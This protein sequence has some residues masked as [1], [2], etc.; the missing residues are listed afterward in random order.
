MTDELEDEIPESVKRLPNF[1][2]GLSFSGRNRTFVKK[3]AEYL[4][5]KLGDD[6]VFYDAWYSSKLK[7]SGADKKLA[8]IY[9]DK[10]KLIVP[11]FSEH[12]E[13]S[14]WLGRVEWPTIKK[15]IEARRDMVVPVLLDGVRASGWKEFGLP[16]RRERKTAAKVAEEILDLYHDRVSGAWDVSIQDLSHGLILAADISNFSALPSKHFRD[17]IAKL[18]SIPE[19]IGLF[20]DASISSLLDGLVAARGGIRHAQLLNLCET[21]INRL[22]V[23]TRKIVQDGV[24]LRI[25]VHYGSYY[26]INKPAINQPKLIVGAAPNECSR[27]VRVA[28]PG[29]VVVSEEFVKN[30]KADEDSELLRHLEPPHTREPIG[31]Y[32]KPGQLSQFRFYKLN[33]NDSPQDTLQQIHAAEEALHKYLVDIEEELVDL[34]TDSDPSLDSKSIGARLTIFAV[35]RLGLQ[36]VPTQI[37]YQKHGNSSV[38]AESV[39]GHRLH[40]NGT[41]YSIEDKKKPQGPLGRAYYSFEPQAVNKLPSYANSPEKYVGKLTRSPWYI[42]RQMV[43]DFGHKA[44]AF[45]AVPFG[46]QTKLP[47]GL[48]CIDTQNPLNSF[49]ASQLEECGE[50]IRRIYGLL[51]ASLLRLRS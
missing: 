17:V 23:S 25:A 13:K 30:W 26:V 34:L 39:N 15:V 36:L 12:Y 50:S 7:G 33:L 45:I 46:L 14:P 29:Q 40:G 32:L 19:E 6:G 9:A 11:F 21:W 5:D 4:R 35:D 49:S 41:K 43:H 18:W 27:L 28:G 51:L 10:C 42:P 20:Q 3:V 31:I 16:I 47:D 2:I 48:L 24:N 8:F 22:R 44:G 1:Q 38:P 37:R